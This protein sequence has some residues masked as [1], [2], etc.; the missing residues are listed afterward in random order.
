MD[1]KV[2]DIL[3]EVTQA[4]DDLPSSAINA[5]LLRGKIAI[6]EIAASAVEKQTLSN[7]EA[8]KATYQKICEILNSTTSTSS[9]GNPF[10]AADAALN[11]KTDEEKIA[12][13]NLLRSRSG[14]SDG[15]KIFT[16]SILAVLEYEGTDEVTLEKKATALTSLVTHFKKYF[17]QEG[18]AETAAFGAAFAVNVDDAICDPLKAAINKLSAAIL[19]SEQTNAPP[20]ADLAELATDA[21]NQS[22]IASRATLDEEENSEE[23]AAAAAKLFGNDEKPE[24]EAPKEVPPPAAPEASEVQEVE[25]ETEQSSEKNEEE[26]AITIGGVMIGCISKK[27]LQAVKMAADEVLKSGIF[28][29]SSTILFL[30][31]APLNRLCA[32]GF[33]LSAS[34]FFGTNAKPK[35][36]SKFEKKSGEW[37]SE[38]DGHFRALAETEEDVVVELSDENSAS[39]SAADEAAT[40][41][42]AGKATN[43]FTAAEGEKIIAATTGLERTA[44]SLH[45]LDAGQ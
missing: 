17:E 36:D 24:D 6:K 32:L 3:S 19:F 25:L 27:E 5:T 15:L 39:P 23:R 30:T 2:A 44:N 8:E 4:T 16:A 12:E 28:F 7:Q 26:A 9:D 18:D 42:E 34:E 43:K 37:K 21:R 31:P 40:S 33:Y 35:T 22:I 20:P 10:Y 14:N 45:A 29:A 13:I 41:T 11:P 1:S 38:W